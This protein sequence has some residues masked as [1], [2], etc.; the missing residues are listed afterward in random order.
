LGNAE[1]KEKKVEEFRNLG[2]QELK[3][4]EN[5]GLRSF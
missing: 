4:L 5:E 2:I 1:F 3:D